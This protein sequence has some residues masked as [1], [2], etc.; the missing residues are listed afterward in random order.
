MKQWIRWW[1]LVAVVSVVAMVVAIVM[2]LAGPT[3]KSAIETLGTKANGALVE[4][5]S[6]SVSVSPLG[7]DIRGIAVTDRRHPMENAIEIGRV[8]VDVALLPLLAG[9]I[10]IDDAH[11]S[12]VAFDTERRVSGALPASEAG[13]SDSD[14]EKAGEAESPMMVA[15]LPSLDDILQRQALA[16]DQAGRALR[17]VVATRRPDIEQRLEA[18]P[19]DAQLK[20]YEQQVEALLQGEIKSLQDFKQK[21]AQLEQLKQRLRSDRDAV[22]A[23]RDTIKISRDELT[24]SLQALRSAPAADLAMLKEQYSLDG[25]GAINI[26]RLLWG[27]E[28]AQWS[29]DAL[30][31]YNKIRPFLPPLEDLP[32]SSDTATE[33]TVPPPRLIG[34]TVHFPTAD[35]WPDFLIRRLSLTANL[36]PGRIEISAQGLT[37]Q[38]QVMPQPMRVNFALQEFP[39]VEQLT[40]DLVLDHRRQPTQ[41]TLTLTAR[42]W[43]LPP[44]ALGSQLTL[45]SASVDVDALAMVKNRSLSVQTEAQFRQAQFV[46]EANSRASEEVLAVLQQVAEFS[47]D[48]G[49]SGSLS[50]PQVQLGSDLDQ[51]L[52]AALGA[53]LKQQQE[54]L[55]QR[56]NRYLNEQISRY[57][58]GM[59][60]EIDFFNQQDAELADA[61]EQLQQLAQKQLD[62]YVEQ[63]RQQAESKLQEKADKKSD[64]LKRKAEDKLK[65]LFN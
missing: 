41:D 15:Q 10:I 40:T 42:Q 56:F 50:Q 18:L 20:Q 49:V 61:S 7:L 48:A 11:L 23:V 58:D 29:A 54:K 33:T 47:M 35:P 25:Q 13:P 30:Y 1:G 53:R 62:D 38:P 8:R 26:S 63:Q 19:N 12:D 55:Q 28:V 31:W 2:V 17:D 27:N 36:Q 34:Q 4:V 51:R 65:S 6:V 39:T 3:V 52:Q 64:E 16:T 44:W 21:K 45:A 60:E 24:Q 9:Q 37:H 22:I 32:S 46:G 57:T 14:A 59:A 43:S 5:D